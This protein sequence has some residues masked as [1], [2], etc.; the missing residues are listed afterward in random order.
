[1]DH[2]RSIVFIDIAWPNDHK[3]LDIIRGNRCGGDL[4]LMAGAM[5]IHPLK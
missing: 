1:M 5:M 4:V 3:K 2:H